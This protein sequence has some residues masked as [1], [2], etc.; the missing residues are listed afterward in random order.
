MCLS[1]FL[2]CLTFIGYRW[3]KSRVS[4]TA[5]NI[6]DKG[7]FY[8]VGKNGIASYLIQM[9]SQLSMMKLRLISI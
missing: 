4:S 3:L 6:S 5:F 1:L 7:D 9:E 2:L 8:I